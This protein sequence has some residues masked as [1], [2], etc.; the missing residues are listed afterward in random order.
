[1]SEPA[2]PMTSSFA[3]PSEGAK[4]NIFVRKLLSHSRLSTSDQQLLVARPF[5]TRQLAPMQRSCARAMRR[6]PHFA[7]AAASTPAMS[8]RPRFAHSPPRYLHRDNAS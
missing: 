5:S 1:M 8:P 3:A 2:P 7:A 6:A 4:L